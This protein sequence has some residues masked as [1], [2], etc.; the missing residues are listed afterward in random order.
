MRVYLA[1]LWTTG[2]VALAACGDDDGRAGD[3]GPDVRAPDAAMDASVRD[4]A[5]APAD[6]L[7]PDASPADASIDAPPADG[8]TVDA[9]VGDG[10]VDAAP[11]IDAPADAGGDA[12]DACS[13]TVCDGACIDTTRDPL[14]C[15]ACD[16]ACPTPA[17]GVA[18]CEASSCGVL[19][20]D[21]YRASGSSCVAAPPRPIAPASTARLTGR[22]PRFRWI[23]GADSE[24]ARVEICADR[25]CATVLESID[26]VGTSAMP[27]SDLP[28]G[29][30][31]WRATAMSGGAPSGA[32]SS[33]TWE[34]TIAAR[35][36]PLDAASSTVLDVNGDGLADVVAGSV[37]YD[38]VHVYLGAEGGLARTPVVIDAPPGSTNFGYSVGRAGDVNGDGFG[39][40]VIGDDGPGAAFLYLG[41]AS[42]PSTTPATSIAHPP[43]SVFFG[44]SASGCDVDGDGYSDLVIGGQGAPGPFVYAGGPTGATSS[45][46]TVL[47]TVNQHSECVGDV[48]GDG[49][50]DVLAGRS[51]FLGGAGGISTTAAVTLVAPPGITGFGNTSAAAGDV[52]GDGYPDVIVGAELIDAAYVFAGGPGGLGA[53]PIATLHSG[54]STRLD[55]AVSGGGDVNRD[56]YA[57]LVASAS[58]SGEAGLYLGGS[59]GVP[60]AP[61]IDLLTGAA[62]SFAS[63]LVAGDTDGDGF[64]D[65]I[66]VGFG[67][68]TPHL[69]VF[70]GSSSGPA[71]TP[72]VDIPLPTGS[73]L[74]G[75]LACVARLVRLAV[76]V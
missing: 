70:A 69:Y 29:V 68:M 24:G 4:A 11:A 10:S 23:L 48:N 47:P 42:G 18:R 34:V 54:A 26:A 33:P 14:H 38:S 27:A 57:D 71:T 40:I 73:T 76:E 7:G 8:S 61:S 64:D 56:G 44:V 35:S 49:Y 3:S 66:V 41:S 43:D 19:C 60:S 62:P 74:G 75:S 63:V 50:A 16:G 55:G 37:A 1:V 72:T 53:D 32:G 31:Y 28:A 58:A 22:R 59:P 30:V 39:D 13:G 45:P 25:A 2:A 12:S 51:L 46:V 6:A 15:G 36:T 65:V 5:E 52:N 9:P 20:D 67:A 17:H 21:G